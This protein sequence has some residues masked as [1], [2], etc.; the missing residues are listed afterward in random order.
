MPLEDI[1]G[2]PKLCNQ[3]ISATCPS[4]PAAPTSE[5]RGA[6][7]RKGEE[8]T[9]QKSKARK[10]RRGM[11]G[12]GWGGVRPR[13]DTLVPGGSDSLRSPDAVRGLR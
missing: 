11:S 3:I 7:E 10:D 13:K 9:R 1:D 6:S 2:E 4:R 12:V 8:R 5:T